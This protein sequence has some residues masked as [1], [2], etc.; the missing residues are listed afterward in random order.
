MYIAKATGSYTIF[1]GHTEIE[2]VEKVHLYELSPAN[3]AVTINCKRSCGECYEDVWRV[4]LTGNQYPQ[5]LEDSQT[6]MLNT[7]SL[8]LTTR[9]IPAGNVTG[10]TSDSDKMVTSSLVV[11]LDNSS[12]WNTAEHLFVNCGIQCKC[13][14][15]RARNRYS[16]Y[17]GLS[18]S[19][20]VYLP[21]PV[22]EEA[23]CPP[24][25]E[26]TCPPYESSCCPMDA[27]MCC[28]PPDAL[29]CNETCGPECYGM[30]LSCHII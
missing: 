22:N 5:I 17:A 23:T 29:F 24:A 21:P 6:E 20:V 15:T 7:S 16:L 1:I 27:E 9:L 10:C 26:C 2:L 8:R 30:C 4:K 14:L 18:T 19:A 25:K 13:L 11:T 3:N 12:V 28:E